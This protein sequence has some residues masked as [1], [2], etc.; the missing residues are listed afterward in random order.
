MIK[1]YCQR[2][3]TSGRSK[4][5]ICLINQ[6]GTGVSF[7]EAYNTAIYLK[8]LRSVVARVMFC[9]VF[10]IAFRMLTVFAGL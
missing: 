10:T 3:L 5:Y 8:R 1:K 6:K 4:R 9:P 7:F 2:L